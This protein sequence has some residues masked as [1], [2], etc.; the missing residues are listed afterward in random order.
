MVPT[1]DSLILY[2]VMTMYTVYY[3]R[4]RTI[5]SFYLSNLIYIIY[6]I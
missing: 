5:S 2:L 1:P 6:I 4:T 3:A